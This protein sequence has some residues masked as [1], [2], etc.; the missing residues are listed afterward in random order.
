MNEF[1]LHK[2]QMNTHLYTTD[3]P[4]EVNLKQMLLAIG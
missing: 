4:Q 3:L 2:V 1:I